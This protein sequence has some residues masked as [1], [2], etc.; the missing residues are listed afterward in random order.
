MHKIGHIITPAK[1]DSHMFVHAW[2]HL[3]VIK[4]HQQTNKKPYETP[5]VVAFYAHYRTRCVRFTCAR[6]VALYLRIF[7]S[8]L[9]P[10]TPLYTKTPF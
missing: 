9:F 6:H 7:V 1:L 2:M 4:Q 8:E 10:K 3:C 5:P